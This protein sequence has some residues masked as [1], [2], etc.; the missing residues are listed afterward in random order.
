MPFFHLF[1]AFVAQIETI[2][3]QGG[4]AFLFLSTLLEGIPLL[5]MVVPGHI[6]I[7]FAGFLAQVGVLNI[8]WVFGLGIAGAVAGDWIGFYIG[9][10]YG[11]AFI[12][13]LRPYFFITDQHI[14][15]AKVLLAKHT[16]KALIIG[17][18]S[19][20]T[21]A[22]MPF[23]VGTTHAPVGRFW[24]FNIIGGVSWAIVSICVG[25]IFGSGYYVVSGYLGKFAVFSI[26]VSLIIL[27]GYRF[28]NVRFHIFKRYELFALI[29]N[30]L[31]L[32]V[33]ARTVQDAWSP[34]SFMANFDVYVNVLANQF[35]HAYA[36]IATVFRW[37]TDIGDAEVILGFGILLTLW[38]ALRKHWRSALITLS[39]IGSTSVVV[40][41]MKTFFLRARPDNA[42]ILILNDASYPSGHAALAAAFFVLVGYFSA[43]KIHSWIWREVV[44]VLCVLAVILIGISR[45][46]LNVH[47]ASD[48]IAGWSLGIFLATG[49]ILAMRYIGALVVKKG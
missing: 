38:F 13:R 49:S 18:F 35:N 37:I 32:Y 12:D 6:S 10:K 5:G 28:V 48:V 44:L 41:L 7:V 27:W 9:R 36:G 34:Q 17:R 43:R 46:I 39:A 31:S 1:S 45:V 8:Y 2:A 42:L 30:L 22:L 4:Y 11:M 26:I 47:W 33:L 29:L 40:G 16:G 20:V 14:D 25:Y 23:L 24:M 15:K 3:T 21:R 19:P